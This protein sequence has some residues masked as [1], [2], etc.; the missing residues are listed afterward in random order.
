VVLYYNKIVSDTNQCGSMCINVNQCGSWF[1]VEAKKM[2][3]LSLMN[4]TKFPR[5]ASNVL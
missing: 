2:S 1:S 4:H 5:Q 3:S